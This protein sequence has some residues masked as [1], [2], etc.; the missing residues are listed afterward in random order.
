MTAQP[1]R[2]KASGSFELSLHHDTYAAQRLEA[3]GGCLMMRGRRRL[4]VF[5]QPRALLLLRYMR[6]R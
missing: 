6:S 5:D 1:Q 2:D 3:R 4:H